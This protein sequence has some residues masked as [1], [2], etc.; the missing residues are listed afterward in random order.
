MTLMVACGGA[1]RICCEPCLMKSRSTTW[2][3]WFTLSISV[4]DP[5]VINCPGAV[6]T[7]VN[8]LATENKLVE[9]EYW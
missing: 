3:N 7:F 8:I 9:E 4:T 5:E 2:P 6:T 1:M